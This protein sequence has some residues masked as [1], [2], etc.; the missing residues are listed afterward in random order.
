MSHWSWLR[1]LAIL[2]CLALVS[3]CEAPPITT[4]TS[5]A[6]SRPTEEEE[7]A[8]LIIREEGF[9]NTSR[10]SGSILASD[11]RAWRYQDGH[12]TETAWS[13]YE[14][15]LN[16]NDRNDWPPYTI[17]FSISA[18]LADQTIQVDVSTYYD[19]G[20]TEN[21]RG[22]NDSVW[23]MKYQAGQWQVLDM[24]ITESWD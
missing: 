14:S 4:S 1:S 19:M 2:T 17:K 7:I 6:V 20:I 13:D 12:L 16:S 21:S 10:T 8:L 9:V 3:S 23:N 24:E 11:K 5:T 15:A 22:G 18:P